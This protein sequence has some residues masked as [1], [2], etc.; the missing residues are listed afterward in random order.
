MERAESRIQAEEAEG[1][2]EGTSRQAE[3]TRGK[4][5]EVAAASVEEA[6]SRQRC[7]LQSAAMG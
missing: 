4:K 3:E 7:D 5:A 2:Q 1:E 6:G